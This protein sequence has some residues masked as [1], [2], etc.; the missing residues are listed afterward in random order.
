MVL[1]LA[2][3]A[4]KRTQHELAVMMA[5]GSRARSCR[6]RESVRRTFVIFCRLSSGSLHLRLCSESDG[7]DLRKCSQKRLR[8]CSDLRR[9]SKPT[10]TGDHHSVA[11]GDGQS[12]GH[13]RRGKQCP[14]CKTCWILAVPPCS[15]GRIL[16][17]CRSLAR[18]TELFHDGEHSRTSKRRLGRR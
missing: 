10:H 4:G 5:T 8:L 17:C 14:P 7:H 9:S 11:S 13:T 15:V 6:S 16:R 12:E 2:W 1:C 18:D 3:L